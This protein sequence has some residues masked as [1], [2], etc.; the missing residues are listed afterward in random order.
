[1]AKEKKTVKGKVKPLSTPE[2]KNQGLTKD[3]LEKKIDELNEK[4]LRDKTPNLN[5]DKDQTK[6]LLDPLGL[7][8]LPNGTFL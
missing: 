2:E 8:I 7:Q 5:P 1:M 6:T 4:K 3:E